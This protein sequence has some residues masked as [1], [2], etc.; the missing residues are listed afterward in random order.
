MRAESVWPE[1]RDRL[2]TTPLVQAADLA[3]AST[4]A[5][6]TREG[7]TIRLDVAVTEAELLRLPPRPSTH[8]ARRASALAF[9]H[10]TFFGAGDLVGPYAKVLNT[11]QA[12]SSRSRPPG[13][14]APRYRLARARSPG[15]RPDA[16]AG[17]GPVGPQRRPGPRPGS[18]RRPRR[19][20]PV[21]CRRFDPASSRGRRSGSHRGRPAA[22]RARRRRFVAP[23]RNDGRPVRPRRAR[24]EAPAGRGA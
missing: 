14:R 3:A 2:A 9:R 4:R 11:R 22:A 10:D 15:R 18:P 12:S 24:R 16:R 19:S 20:A 5:R 7:R 23:A 21:G 1:L 13:L 6:L 8:R 17:H